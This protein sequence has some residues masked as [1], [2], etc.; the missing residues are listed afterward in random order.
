MTKYKEMH[1]KIP[2]LIPPPLLQASTIASI[3]S[4]TGEPAWRQVLSPEDTILATS[5]P[6]A[7]TPATATV[8]SGGRTVRLWSPVDGSMMWETSLGVGG[9]PPS[10]AMGGGGAEEAAA[11][12][13][14]ESGAGVVST[15]RG[16]VVVLGAGGIHVLAAESGAVLGQWWCEPA[17]E[18]DLAALVGLDVQVCMYTRHTN[19]QY[20]STE[21]I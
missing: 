18:P 14:E 10:A 11:A 13:V 5:A 15:E 20:H 1:I 8:S 21:Y 2:L 12:A 17:R 6:N 4:V 9:T 7:R 19:I 3:N 16:Y